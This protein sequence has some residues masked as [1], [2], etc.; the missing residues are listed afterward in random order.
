[1]WL[2]LSST[3][4]E[5]RGPPARPATLTSSKAAGQKAR[6][7]GSSNTGIAVLGDHAP[8]SNPALGSDHVLKSPV[9]LKCPARGNLGA[10]PQ[11]IQH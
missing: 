11:E 9:V 2:W 7:P 1:M 6:A 4:A 3:G 8:H 10:S 5:P